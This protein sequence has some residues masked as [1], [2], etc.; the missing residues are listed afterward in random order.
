MHPRQPLASADVGATQAPSAKTR[1]QHKSSDHALLRGRRLLLTSRPGRYLVLLLREERERGA[2]EEEVGASEVLGLAESAGEDEERELCIS[3]AMCGGRPEGN[4]AEFRGDCLRDL[5][6]SIRLDDLTCRFGATLKLAS[7]V[8][9]SPPPPSNAASCLKPSLNAVSTALVQFD[10]LD[11][12]P[13]GSLPHALK[14]RRRF[15]PL[16]VG[17][18]L[19]PLGRRMVVRQTQT[20]HALR[21]NLHTLCFRLPELDKGQLLVLFLLSGKFVDP[22]HLL[23]NLL[24]I[25]FDVA[26]NIVDISY[27]LCLDIL[28]TV[29]VAEEFEKTGEF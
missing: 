27:A 23:I 2:G 20:M 25:V 14:R 11:Q 6:T 21:K 10:F 16:Q 26:I 17:S 28:C 22:G 29:G 18:P 19:I 13:R 7:S 12:D 5:Q 1:S 15:L 3:D 24:E 8:E 4:A 9:S